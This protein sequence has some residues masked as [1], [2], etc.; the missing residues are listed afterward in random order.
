VKNPSL[1]D[2][3]KIPFHY[4][5][6]DSLIKMA[7]LFNSNKLSCFVSPKKM[8]RKA[9]DGNFKKATRVFTQTIQQFFCPPKIEVEMIFHS[10]RFEWISSSWPRSLWPSPNGFPVGTDIEDTCFDFL[11]EMVKSSCIN[12]ILF[13]NIKYSRFLE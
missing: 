3:L 10:I 5:Q 6:R 7:G 8:Q 1:T 9:W 11:L 12:P 13:Y 2:F 4:L